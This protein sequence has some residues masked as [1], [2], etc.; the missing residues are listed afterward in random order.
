MMDII[1]G[2]MKVLARLCADPQERGDRGFFEELTPRQP[3]KTGDI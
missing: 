3:I 2:W 1:V